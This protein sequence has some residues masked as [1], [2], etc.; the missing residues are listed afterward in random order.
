MLKAAAVMAI[1][2]IASTPKATIRMAIKK[3][4]FVLSRRP[5]FAGL[6]LGVTGIPS[7]VSC[8]PPERF[9][10][11]SPMRWSRRSWLRGIPVATF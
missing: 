8:S 5:P 9:S 4:L 2:A 1:A 10:S 6:P 7:D 3:A 11:V